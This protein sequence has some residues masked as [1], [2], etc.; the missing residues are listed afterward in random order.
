MTPYL[1]PFLVTFLSIIIFDIN[2]KR[3]GKLVYYLLY[4][5]LVLLIGLRFKVGGDTINYM[6][7]FEWQ[8][9]LE[10]IQFT[11]GDLLQPGYNLLVGVSKTISPKFYVFQLIHSFLINT[12]LFVFIYKNVPYKFTALFCL[13]FVCYLYFTCEILRE[14][15]SILIFAFLYKPLVNKKW[16]T[17]YLGV[18]VCVMFHLSSLI[19]IFFPLLTGL[20]FDKRY[21]ILIVIISLGLI[22]LN[23]LFLLLENVIIIG[24]KVS[25]YANENHGLL[26]DILLCCRKGGFPIFFSLIVKFGCRRNL[27]FENQ[28]AC[29]GIF[30]VMSLFNPVI[31]GRITNYFILFFVLSFSFEIIDF[32]KSNNRKLI[33]NAAVLSILFILLYGSGYTMYN[34]YKLYTPYSSVL[35]PISYNRNIF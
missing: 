14:V 27:K 26:A 12:L 24:D 10:N 35:N 4:I 2:R 3:G 17:Y 30:G 29:L 5:Y 25:T 21:F 1:I 11:F 16:I 20:R 32:I 33:H 8:D 31:F 23:R 19:L 6:G 18:A 7:Y 9:D 15:I 22:G 34:I 13:Y 28:L